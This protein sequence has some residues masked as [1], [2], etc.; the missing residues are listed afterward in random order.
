[1][2]N[3]SIGQCGRLLASVSQVNN[4]EIIEVPIANVNFLHKL[5]LVILDCFVT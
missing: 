3:R 2:L 5:R 4:S 1:M